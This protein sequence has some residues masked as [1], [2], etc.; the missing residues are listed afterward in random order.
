M[1]PKLHWFFAVSR[2][3]GREAILDSYLAV[4]AA[5]PTV[6]S[7]LKVAVVQIGIWRMNFQFLSNL[8]IGWFA[9]FIFLSF[10]FVF[11]NGSGLFLTKGTV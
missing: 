1:R 8:E 6:S 9:K 7:L 10:V 11:F 5:Y 3:S 2:K 4:P